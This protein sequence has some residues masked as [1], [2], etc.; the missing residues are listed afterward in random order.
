MR[1]NSGKVYAAVFACAV[2]LL[3]AAGGEARENSFRRTAGRGFGL[4]NA[5]PYPSLRTKI[6][7]MA[8]S[9]T[10]DKVLEYN[11]IPG[12]VAIVSAGDSGPMVFAKGKGRIETSTPMRLEDKFRIASI[13]K[14]FTAEM[15]LILADE[16]KLELDAPVGRYV[17]NVPNGDIITIRMLLNHTSG[18]QDK[19]SAEYILYRET[20]ENPLR[21]WD[22]REL[23]DL[24]TAGKEHGTPG[25]GHLYSNAGY[26]LLGIVIE[27]VTGQSLQEFLE[28][29]I[30]AP[31]GLDDTYYPGGPEIAPP[32]AHGYD[33]AEDVTWVDPSWDFTAGGMVSSA[34]DLYRWARAFSRGD[35]ISPGM[36]AERKEWV[37][38]PG[39]EGQLR[40]GL[41][42]QKLGGWEGHSGGFSGWQSNAYYHPG[43]DAAL[44]V[45]MNK[46]S[47]D[48]SDALAGQQS[49]AW[50][51]NVLV[52][53]SI[54]RWYIDA[55]TP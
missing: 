36:L 29:S 51:A 39:G 19:M 22:P 47:I 18:I 35:L 52:P 30:T 50:T 9:L 5:Y 33:G 38:V 31:L 2:I 17:R 13:T 37:D 6:T 26:I 53:G 48:G 12:A 40:Y 55:I 28:Y 23:F 34:G 15:V 7:R 25:E 14:S 42:M 8:I 49:F 45:L 24:Y 10:L 46:T 20:R 3:S 11:N 43:A 54:P 1:I 32:H 41:G 21:K 16:G 27:N 4:D 44:V